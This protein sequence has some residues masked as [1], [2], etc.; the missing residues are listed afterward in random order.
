MRKVTDIS[1]I[2][3]QNCG[4]YTG[5]LKNELALVNTSSIDNQWKL[6]IQNLPK[7]KKSVW[8]KILIASSLIELALF[9]DY[10]IKILHDLKNNPLEGDILFQTKLSE[11]IYKNFENIWKNRKKLI[12]SLGLTKTKKTARRGARCAAP[13]RAIFLFF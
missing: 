1:K 12:S 3:L 13:R 5:K 2:K 8:A 10:L 6:Y 11:L 9:D 7:K 4:E